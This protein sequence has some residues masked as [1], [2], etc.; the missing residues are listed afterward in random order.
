MT[1]N[2]R[3]IACCKCACIT[4]NAALKFQADVYAILMLWNEYGN[5]WSTHFMEQLATNL[6]WTISHSVS[7]SGGQVTSAAPTLCVLEVVPP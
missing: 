7:V 5:Q 3:F 2:D 6:S 4:V 1:K